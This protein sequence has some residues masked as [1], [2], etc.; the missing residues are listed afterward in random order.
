HLDSSRFAL[1]A[2]EKFL[3]G[4]RAYAEVSARRRAD[5]VLAAHDE[6]ETAMK[7]ILS[8]ESECDLS[9]GELARL[10]TELQRLSAEEHALQAE[11]AAFQRSYE[12]NDGKNAID[13]EQAHHEAAEK[14]KEAECAAAELADAVRGRKSCSD[15]H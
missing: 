10:K 2:V 4:Y 5:R 11:I 12:K 8:A 7:E 13:L 9:L 3:T 6:Y 15:E 1:A 14:R